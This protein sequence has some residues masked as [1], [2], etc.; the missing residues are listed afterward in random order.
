MAHEPKIGLALGAGGARGLAHILMLETFEELGLRPHKIAGGSIGAIIGALYASGKSA[1]EVRLI[2]DELV[3]RAPDGW[4]KAFFK[5]DLFQ[6]IELVDPEFGRG[7]LIGGHAF[8]A[9]L[10]ERIE[11]S[12]FEDL[13]IPLAIVATDFWKYEQVVY[14]SGELQSAIQGSMAAPGLFTPV[15]RDNRV[16]VDGGAVNPVPFDILKDSSEWTVAVSVAG[17]RSVKE[18]FS[19]LDALFNTFQIMQ[20]SILAEK[21]K[22]SPPDILITPRIFDVRS[23]EF[24]KVDSIYTQALPA[25]E[26]LKRELARRMTS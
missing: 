16:L 22:N 11:V 20:H 6:W 14:E 23:F 12:R 15:R 5:K 8:P 13:D 25:K 26:T 18:D 2:V 3:L 10:C 4:K 1:R 19:F 21:C 9:Y 24:H 7:G 17:Q